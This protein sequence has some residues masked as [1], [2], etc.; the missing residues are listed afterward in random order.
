M[1]RACDGWR[2][3]LGEGEGDSGT[4]EHMLQSSIYIN[5]WPDADAD[6]ERKHPPRDSC[7]QESIAALHKSLVGSPVSDREQ[8]CASHTAD[9]WDS[10]E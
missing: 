9:T 10:S 5:G 8:T 2:W 3:P 7:R 4:Y 6:A 1:T